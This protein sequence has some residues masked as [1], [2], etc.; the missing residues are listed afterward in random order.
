MSE[1]QGLT[2]HFSWME[3]TENQVTLA[4][5]L[6]SLLMIKQNVVIWISCESSSKFPTVNQ[7]QQP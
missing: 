1:T 3:F 6:L 2:E 7:I 4:K 5:K